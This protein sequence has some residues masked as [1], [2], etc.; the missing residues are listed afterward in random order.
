MLGHKPHVF[1]SKTAGTYRGLKF[2]N[3]DCDTP[4]VL[5]N[6]PLINA[7]VQALTATLL[8]AAVM[9]GFVVFSAEPRL[10]DDDASFH[11]PLSTTVLGSLSRPRMWS[12]AVR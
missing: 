12:S 7:L 3:L 6:L 11:R 1:K 8:F 9:Y 5:E 2:R 10:R 4:P